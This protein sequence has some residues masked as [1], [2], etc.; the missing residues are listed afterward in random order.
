MVRNNVYSKQTKSNQI[1]PFVEKPL[2]DECVMND[3]TLIWRG[4]YNR[5][6]PSVWKFGQFEKHILDCSLLLIDKVGKVSATHRGDPIRVC[7]AIS[8]AVNSPDDDGALLGNWSGDFS[9]GTAPTKWVGSV[10]IMQ[11]Y[12]KKQKPVKFGQCWVFAGVVSTSKSIRR[13]I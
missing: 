7:R 11:Q 6:R 2:R 9:G 12:Y 5:L 3:T 10:E 1:I 13:G 4:S 8:A